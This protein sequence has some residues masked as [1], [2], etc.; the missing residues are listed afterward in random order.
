MASK[1]D[2]EAG[3]A[4][5]RLY[6]RND[7][8]RQLATAIKS[9]GESVLQ[10]GASA[11]RAGAG[12]TAGGLALLGPLTASAV[13]FAKTADDIATTAGRLQMPA[14][15]VSELAH[16][17]KMTDV[18]AA[19]LEKGL[20]NLRLKTQEAAEG[21][22]TLRDRFAALGLSWHQLAAQPL[23]KQLETVADA[24]AGLKS[25]NEQAAAAFDLLGKSGKEMLPL[26]VS[27]SAGIR[28]WRAEA[29]QMGIA[30]S[31]ADV[32]MGGQL[33]DNLDRLK[34]SLAGVALQIGAALAPTAIAAT[35]AVSGML[36]KGIEWVQQNQAVVQTVAAV[37]AGLVAAGAA[38]ATLGA[39]AYAAGSVLAILGGAILTVSGVAGRI[40]GAI[41]APFRLLGT[42]AAGAAARI[43][44]AF[45]S[46][47]GGM[48]AGAAAFAGVAGTITAGAARAGAALVSTLGAAAAAAT[49]ALTTGVQT[50]GQRL[51]AALLT[52]LRGLPAAA[53]SAA[54][55]TQAAFA[56]LGQYARAAAPLIATPLAK[57]R[58]AVVTPIA[59]RL[60]PAWVREPLAKSAAM[61]R[62]DAGKIGSA[63]SGAFGRVPAIARGVAVATVAAWRGVGP[64]VS[65]GLV[66]A[67]TGVFARVR[68]MAAATGGFLRRS[69][70]LSAA[71][72]GLGRGLGGAMGG[73][74]GAAGMLGAIGLGGAFAPLLAMAPMVL[75]VLGSIGTALAAVA[76][77]VMLLAA[78]VAAG[79]VA[80]VNWSSSGQAAW[81]G[82]LAAVQ[83]IAAT[84]RDTFG[85]V[86]DAILGGQWALAGKLAIAGLKLA[87]FQGL[88]AIQDAFPRVFGA[89]LR[90]VGK[91][92]DGVVKA[93]G[94][95]TG[96]LTDQWNN[97]GKATLD[98]ILEVA[99]LIPDI[100]QNA[101]EGIA[102]TMLE[103]AASSPLMG[104]LMKP[105]L[106]VDMSDEQA[107]AQAMEEARRPVLKRNLEW[108]IEQAKK[109]GKDTTQLEADLAAL[110]GPQQKVDV[111]ADARQAVKAYTDQ[112]RSDVANAGTGG[113]AGEGPVSQALDSFLT[114]LE[115]G[116]SVA[117]AQAE[118]DALKAGLAA[119]KEA[120]AAETGAAAGAAGGTAAAGS[121]SAPAA[122]AT[123][124]PRGI[125]L[126]PTY[127][128]AAAQAAGQM[129]SGAS[130]QEKMATSIHE[131]AKT[132]HELGL[133]S[134]KQTVSNEHVVTM[135]ER[136]LAAMT[137]G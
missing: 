29:R 16:A 95:V 131:M 114:K 4:F 126:G 117:D 112:L 72:G 76:S 84:L 77:P 61:A 33:S 11:M 12:L 43:G 60:A 118:F 109:E 15:A 100:W 66:P 9:A 85:G 88:A 17:M 62:A 38:V 108:A 94:K 50:A 31:D 45:A 79:A 97:W 96:F 8:T 25:P 56:R 5:V 106:G 21:S 82:L 22:K 34:D 51:A 83:P 19:G 122:D 119:A 91:V 129:G 30:L 137:Y 3:R 111:L 39:A 58:T 99:G 41:V 81:Q 68:S 6:L 40:G 135:Y 133:L 123:A 10:L 28:Q 64:A 53:R 74:V 93:W 20:G 2:I 124:V 105:I 132:L 70:S 127:S 27:G 80:W 87:V 116:L 48:R 59:A 86:K 14:S 104:K 78:G 57:L 73:L 103:A 54:A 121:P 75:G 110:G 24:I 67:M 44:T 35:R 1:A 134:R 37:G 36:A 26:L 65:R 130:P 49:R 120:K 90:T 89:V 13:G 71:G 107:K 92:G 101:V 115:S 69:L 47:W 125:A 7:L 136:F 46:V 55:A 98:T 32:A 52:P 113:T 63:L 23:D 42:V 102:N 18:S 128:A